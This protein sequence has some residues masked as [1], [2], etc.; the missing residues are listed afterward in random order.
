MGIQPEHGL[1][2]YVSSR[3][4]AA[5]NW[6]ETYGVTRNFTLL[7]S[8][9]DLMVTETVPLVAPAGTVAVRKE[10]D[11]FVNAAVVPLK[12]TAVTVER[13]PPRMVMVAPALPVAGS[14]FTNAW[15]PL[16]KLKTVPSSPVPPPLVT[17]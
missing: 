11:P 16:L 6:N 8:V 9:P 13:L 4:P 5:R 2:Y 7:F 17:P 10:F 15:R 1:Q 12:L 3:N 14:S